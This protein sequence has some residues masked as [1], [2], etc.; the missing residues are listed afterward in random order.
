MSEANHTR[1]RGPRK[2]ASREFTRTDAGEPAG[3]ADRNERLDSLGLVAHN[4]TDAEVSSIWEQLR[5][6]RFVI[7][8]GGDN[9]SIPVILN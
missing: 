3:A 8:H 9:E 6:G 1:V 2:P 5:Y 7:C 4:L